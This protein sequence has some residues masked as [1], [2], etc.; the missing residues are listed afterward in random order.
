MLIVGGR[1]KLSTQLMS[2]AH[3]R[4]GGNWS[5]NEE[6]LKTRGSLHRSWLSA[7]MDG[8]LT[9]LHQKRSQAADGEMRGCGQCSSAQRPALPYRTRKTSVT[10]TLIVLETATSQVP[11]LPGFHTFWLPEHTD[12][13][14]P[15]SLRNYPS[16]LRLH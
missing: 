5:R 7:G 12:S 10:F 4:A 6:L 9:H 14:K 16:Q 15:K 2:P 3:P 1:G 8:L 11:T 13:T